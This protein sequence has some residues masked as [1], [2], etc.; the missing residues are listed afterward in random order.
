MADAPLLAEI[1]LWGQTLGAVY[2]PA[3]GPPLF[4]YDPAFRRGGLEVSPRF[5]PLSSEGPRAFAELMRSPAFEGLPGLLADALPDRFGNAVI[6]KYF[7]ERGQGQATL[8]PVQ[9]LLY[10]GKRAMGALSFHPAQELE[11]TSRGQ[12]ALELSTLVTSARAVIEGNSVVVLPEIMSLSASPGGARAKA[13]VLWN[14]E[15][16]EM[17]SAFAKREPGDQDWLIKFDGVGELERPDPSSR[18]FNRIEYAYS[19]MAREAGLQMSETRLLEERGLAHFMTRRF[20]RC[21]GQR[22]HMHSLGGMEHVDYNQP[23]SYSYEQFM[24]L[25]L[26]LGLGYP[27]REQAFLRAAFNLVVVNQDDHVKNLA[28]LMDR[29]GTWSLAPAYDLTYARGQGY[30]RR[31]QM[32]LAGKRDDFTAGDLTSFASKFGI[33][34]AGRPQLEQLAAALENWSEH[35][36]AAGL[37][38][39]RAE[40]L[41]SE[42]RSSLL[43][44]H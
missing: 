26:E 20:D 43:A 10:I 30:T 44:E 1:R 24:R 14:P 37:D 11:L 35:A 28:F 27:A 36:S 29:R 33:H 34:H 19:L 39:D 31:H 38:P 16:D 18:P 2:E 5:L 7:S 13:V 4:E 23:G 21:D 32:S 22:L 40:N 25:V 9:K 6:A 8:S 15:R 3:E 41:Q 12:E 42:F 17:R